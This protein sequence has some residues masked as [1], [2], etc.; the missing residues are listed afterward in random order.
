M[1]TLPKSSKPAAAPQLLL[2]NDPFV[3]IDPVDLKHVLG[4]I[5]TNRGDLHV[6]SSLMSFVDNDHPIGARC[7]GE[8]APSTTSRAYI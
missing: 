6:D 8:R 7:R 1:P 4:D 3:D 5:Q 2:D